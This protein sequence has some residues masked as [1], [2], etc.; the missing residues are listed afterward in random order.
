MFKIAAIIAALAL[1]LTACTADSVDGREDALVG[2]PVPP[3]AWE[4]KLVLKD[5]T[6]GCQP[7]PYIEAVVID[8][9]GMP[10]IKGDDT[11]FWDCVAM[12]DLPES[13]VLC[14]HKV[15]ED[16]TLS[17]SLGQTWGTYVAGTCMY[18]FQ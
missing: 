14:E 5:Q 6:T 13:Y 18:Q 12:P 2:C 10:Y 11:G 9:C 8:P 1:A 4:L 15:T 7:I 3:E 16:L 17:L